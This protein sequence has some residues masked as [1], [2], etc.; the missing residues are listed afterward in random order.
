[1]SI[2]HNGR[3]S[4]PLYHGTT[5]AFIDSIKADGLGAVDPLKEMKAKDLMQALFDLAEKQNWT[6]GAWPTYREKLKPLLLQSRTEIYNFKHG[7]TYLTYSFALAKVYA[8]ESPEGCEYFYYL[9]ILVKIL[10][11]RNVPEIHNFTEHPVFKIWEKPN[12]PYIVKLEGIKL[13]DIETEV[14]V[15]LSQ[16]IISI[17]N[18]LSKGLP[19]AQSFKLTT[20][21]PPESLE[22]IRLGSW[23]D[24]ATELIESNYLEL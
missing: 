19:D 18:N 6:D 3:F 20:V 13:S 8:T 9:R 21:I 10:A 11:H 12:D 23:N 22:V 7:G 16:Q 24:T 5:S 17:E 14:D 4:I 15:E 2:I 1:M